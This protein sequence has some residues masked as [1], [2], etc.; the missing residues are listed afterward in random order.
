M[1]ALPKLLLLVIVAVAAWYAMRWLNRPPAQMS[2]G[3]RRRTAGPAARSAIEAEDL[4]ACGVCGTY[5]SLN[6]RGCGKAGCPRPG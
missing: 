4:V 2:A 6:A 5:V 1:I 3:M